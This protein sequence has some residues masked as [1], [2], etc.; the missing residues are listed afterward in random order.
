MKNP[1]DSMS[2]AE[3]LEIA[4]GELPL[5][6]AEAEEIIRSAALE[7]A[8]ARGFRIPSSGNSKQEVRTFASC[9][10]HQLG[11]LVVAEMG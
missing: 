7:R 11:Y 9:L 4:A 3:L 6:R 10:E 2:Y 5:T 1:L 8:T